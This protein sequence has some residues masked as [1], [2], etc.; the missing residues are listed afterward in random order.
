MAG[1]KT[2]MRRKVSLGVLVW[3]V[4]GMF[5]AADHG[6]LD[7]LDGLEGILSAVLAVIL[8]PLVVLSVHVAI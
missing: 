6:F 2:M 8:W 5:V 7:R 3:V 4:V 1:V